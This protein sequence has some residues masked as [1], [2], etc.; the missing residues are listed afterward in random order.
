M[1]GKPGR[2]PGV[3]EFVKSGPKADIVLLMIGNNDVYKPYK[4]VSENR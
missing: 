2:E 1:D 3:R 4:D